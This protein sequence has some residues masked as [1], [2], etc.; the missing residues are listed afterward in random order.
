MRSKQLF[1][2]TKS[3][4][5]EGHQLLFSNTCKKGYG[6]RK[7]RSLVG[8]G[9]EKSFSSTTDGVISE[10]V[11]VLKLCAENFCLIVPLYTI[12]KYPLCLLSFLVF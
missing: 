10:K 3:G 8:L 9:I 6:G 1:V 4:L 12:R 2:T 7:L 11:A 5:E